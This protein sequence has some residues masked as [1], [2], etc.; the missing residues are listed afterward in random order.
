M[1]YKSQFFRSVCPR[2]SEL[3]HTVG[4]YYIKWV[5]ILLGYIV[6]YEMGQDFLD[7]QYMCFKSLYLKSIK[8]YIKWVTT[9]WTYCIHPLHLCTKFK[10]TNACDSRHCKVFFQN[11]HRRKIH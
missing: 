4:S 2:S 10:D 8:R 6:L 1:C 9:S 11:V 5:A 7:R 3:V